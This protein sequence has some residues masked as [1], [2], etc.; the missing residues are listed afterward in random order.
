MESKLGLLVLGLFLYS[1]LNL[2]TK[3]TTSR[4]LRLLLHLSRTQA[5]RHPLSTHSPSFC[6]QNTPAII[7]KTHPP[8]PEK[9]GKPKAELLPFILN[10]SYN[11]NLAKNR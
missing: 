7:N 2:T 4:H 11:P 1:S 3:K 9:Q 10:K 8:Q 5:H 6:S